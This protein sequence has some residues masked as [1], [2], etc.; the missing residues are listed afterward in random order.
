MWA[1]GNS[2]TIQR[3]LAGPLRTQRTFKKRL[4]KKNLRQGVP[5]AILFVLLTRGYTFK[6]R[7]KKKKRFDQNRSNELNRGESNQNEPNRSESNRI[8]AIIH[9]HVLLI[10]GVRPRECTRALRSSGA[11]FG[12]E[13]VFSLLNLEMGL[14]NYFKNQPT[15]SSS[16]PGAPL[17]RAGG[18]GATSM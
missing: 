13:V 4:E 11:R 8:R 12:N 3:R 17:E 9:R 2:L 18:I 1:S 10:V 15:P 14:L 16:P 7:Q 6:E 5:S